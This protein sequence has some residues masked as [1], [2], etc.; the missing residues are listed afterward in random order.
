MKKM[1][2]IIFPRIEPGSSYVPGRRAN[3]C[4][5][6]LVALDTIG[7]YYIPAITTEDFLT[8]WYGGKLVPDP[9]KVS[10]LI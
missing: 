3:H 10:F 2:I 4:T 6:Q 1:Q 8:Y 9:R 5:T 7:W